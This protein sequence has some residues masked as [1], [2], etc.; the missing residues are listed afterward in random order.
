[1]KLA[2]I[3]LGFFVFSV[4][5]AQAQGMAESPS[6]VKRLDEK[7]NIKP[8]SV[9]YWLVPKKRLSAA[10]AVASVSYSSELRVTNNPPN[11]SGLQGLA[12][13]NIGS[14]KYSFTAYSL[15][16]V[17]GFTEMNNFGARVGTSIGGTQL[18][19]SILGSIQNSYSQKTG[20]DDIFITWSRKWDS[21]KVL[22]R[23]RVELGISPE[24]PESSTQGNNTEEK[25]AS[26]GFRL[27]LELGVGMKNP[28]YNL[29]VFGNYT[30]YGTR[31]YRSSGNSTDTETTGGNSSSIGVFAEFLGSV[32]D[33]G[34]RVS[35]VKYESSTS[36]TGSQQSTSEARNNFNYEVLVNW[37]F[38]PLMD[39]SVNVALVEFNSTA[40][41]QVIYPVNKSAYVT[42]IGFRYLF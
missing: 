1:M 24:K 20:L 29:G 7:L 18:S 22:V 6:E 38:R 10:L 42:G 31:V 32:V 23:S 17:Y 26:G 3:C 36:K 21:D 14:I 16:L 4:T 2:S 40:S 19:Y 30:F 34:V 9:F 5:F 33:G 8:D 12:G 28:K 27:P 13:S 15:N 11:G 39:I 41:A 35:S 37:R 25:N